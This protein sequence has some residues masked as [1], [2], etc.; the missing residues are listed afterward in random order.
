MDLALLVSRSVILDP[1]GAEM[2]PGAAEA[3]DKTTAS[4]AGGVS[5]A[6]AYSSRSA[7]GAQGPEMTRG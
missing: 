1:G 2:M 3:V 5:P 7:I 4:A 6:A